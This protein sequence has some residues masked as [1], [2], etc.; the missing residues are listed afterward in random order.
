MQCKRIKISLQIQDKVSGFPILHTGPQRRGTTG[1]R[2]ASAPTLHGDVRT[3]GP[4]TGPPAAADRSQVPEA[5]HEPNTEMSNKLF[6][7]VLWGQ[8]TNV[9]GETSCASVPGSSLDSEL[10]Y[11]YTGGVL[12]G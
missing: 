11:K 1:D 6:P 12:E 9:S 2:T 5:C 4:Y 10:N 3:G 7:I 8:K